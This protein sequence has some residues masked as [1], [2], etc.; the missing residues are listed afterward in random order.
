MIPHVKH[1][2]DWEDLGDRYYNVMDNDSNVY[3]DGSTISRKT[4]AAL[5]LPIVET[6]DDEEAHIRL[7]NA[8]FLGIRD[9]K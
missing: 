1:G 4:V 2:F 3:A 5:G 7:I 8:A 6:A 9:L